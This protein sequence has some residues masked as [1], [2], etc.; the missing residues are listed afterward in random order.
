V[1]HRRLALLV[2]YLVAACADRTPRSDGGAPPGTAAAAP[3]AAEAPRPAWAKDPVLRFLPR[4]PAVAAVVFDL[5]QTG[6]TVEL[7]LR[8]IAGAL[9]LEAD[10]DR[11]LRRAAAGVG[12][13]LDAAS[14]ARWGVDGRRSVGLAL[15]GRG[16]LLFA[17]I[18]VVRFAT[19]E[20]RLRETLP[21][22]AT[23]ARARG[24]VVASI[25]TEARFAYG[26]RDGYALVAAPSDDTSARAAVLR[27]GLEALLRATP[28]ESLASSETFF[29]SAGRLRP[30][31]AALLA[32]DGDRLHAL[33]AQQPG[34]TE[35]EKRS[36]RSFYAGLRGVAFGA[37]VEPKQLRLELFA[38]MD[39]MGDWQRIFAAEPSAMLAGLIPSAAP[40]LSHFAFDANALIDKLL[41]LDPEARRQLAQASADLEAGLGIHLERDLLRKL[42]GR[43]AFAFTGLDR[44]LLDVALDPDRGEEL[45]TRIHL[46]GV[47]ELRDESGFRKALENAKRYLDRQRSRLALAEDK[48]IF[49]LRYGIAPVATLA[50]R[51]KALLFALGRGELRRALRAAERPAAPGPHPAGE[52]NFWA[53][54]DFGALLTEI[55]GLDLA[56]LGP[57]RSATAR[58]F[59][60]TRLTPLF[61]IFAGAVLAARVGGSG[62]RMEA[63]LEMR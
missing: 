40:V 43:F 54:L 4:K 35:E 17:A 23:L 41:E 60:E 32:L 11:V 58:D 1:D 53:R 28:A 38:A 57:E 14:R 29:R 59:I 25:G 5:A 12:N 22:E 47:A 10:L 33:A 63:T 48:G 39:R 26:S 21:R 20:E 44:D 24:V 9:G 56:P 6:R 51:E 18:P 45:L 16:E 7:H 61:R 52:N 31:I 49:E 62:F 13:P 30:P 15:D 8:R 37:R 34:L 27:K 3:L 55:Q 2:A 36:L 50:V 42:T 19:F 46:V